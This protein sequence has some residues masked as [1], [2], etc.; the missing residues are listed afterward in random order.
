MDT[1]TLSCNDFCFYVILPMG[2]VLPPIV[3]KGL[4]NDT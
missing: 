4:Q 3:C 2:W 1:T